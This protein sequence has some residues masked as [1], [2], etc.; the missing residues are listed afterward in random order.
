MK[1]L[2][3]VAALV[4]GLAMPAWGQGYE[5]GMDAAKRGDFAAA[6]KEW[7]PLAE[8]GD[9][10][11]QFLMGQ[12]YLDGT[13]V[14]QDY[15]QAVT[16][17]RQAAEQRMGAAQASLGVFYRDGRGVA[18]DYVQAH[19]WFNLAGRPGVL[20][21]IRGMRDRLAEK[22]TPAQIAEAQRLAGAWLAKN[23]CEGCSNEGRRMV[24][25]WGPKQRAAVPSPGPPASDPTITRQQNALTQRQLASLGYDPGPADGVIGPKTRAA[26]RAFQVREGLPV[27]GAIS[28]DLNLE[29]LLEAERR[30]VLSSHK[31]AVLDEAR[32]RGLVPEP[33]SRSR[34]LLNRMNRL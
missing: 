9:T 5:P 16:W 23:G 28:A 25:A 26:I 10:V 29:V 3:V 11:A 19:M 21:D 14:P 20:S 18:Q 15:V 8:R 24:R 32:R 13:G 12:M 2:L 27:T 33:K 22:M 31:Q 30:G 4:V 1:R 6:V 7:T 34:K 17:Y